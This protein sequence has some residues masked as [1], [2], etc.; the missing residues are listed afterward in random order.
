MRMRTI[1]II[2]PV[3]A[4][5]V[6][7]LVVAATRSRPDPVRGILVVAS[8]NVYGDIARQIG[9]RDVSVTSILT[10]PNADPHLY[11]PGTRSG[12]E[13]ARAR[14]LIANG[15]GYDTFVSRLAAASPSGKRV[16]VTIADA[17]QVSG[18]DANPHLWYDV[19]RLAAIAGA[20][21]GGLARVDPGHRARYR[22]GVQRFLARLAPLRR[23][24]A[25]IRRA[26]A[27]AAV[28]YTE[29][30]PGYLLA[31]AGL[32]NLAPPAFT[33]AIQNGSEP[34]ASAVSA[35]TLLVARGRV[36]VLLYNSQAVSPI[37]SRIRAAAADA[38]VP[39]VGVSETLPPHLDFQTWQLRQARA[40]AGALGL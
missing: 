22:A 40:L 32:R 8:T 6:A 34:S 7:G 29:P 3:V 12:L 37:T 14:L 4:L 27:G 9:G 31:A 36:R 15:L 13:V 5:T 28:A 35:M 26:E 39:V 19:P 16:L 2:V 21:A 20:I 38:G 17:L 18:R 10:D 24:V 11:Q 33:R 23:Q 25:A 1:I 30:V